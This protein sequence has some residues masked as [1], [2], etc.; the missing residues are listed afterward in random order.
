MC[1]K[2]G[3][4]YKK[5]PS[6]YSLNNKDSIGGGGGGGGGSGDDRDED[7]VECAWRM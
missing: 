1:V 6:L 2:P 5:Q 7:P 3:V 4:D